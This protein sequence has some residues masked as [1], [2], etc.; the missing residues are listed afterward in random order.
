MI[1]P[2]LTLSVPSVALSVNQELLLVM[3]SLKRMHMEGHLL[4]V[5]KILLIILIITLVWYDE[6]IG[7]QQVISYEA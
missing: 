5:S 4:W 1:A 3:S 6:I 7:I 2:E